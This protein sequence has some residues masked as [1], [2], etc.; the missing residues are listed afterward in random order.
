MGENGLSAGMLPETHLAARVAKLEAERDHWKGVAQRLGACMTC[1]GPAGAPEPYGCTDC[2]NTGFSGEYHTAIAD[3][4]DENSALAAA[5]CVLPPGEGLVGGEGG[6]PFCKVNVEVDKMREEIKRLAKILRENIIANDAGENRLFLGGSIYTGAPVDWARNVLVLI[7]DILTDTA[8]GTMTGE[9][10]AS[11]VR[12]L[13]E[14]ALF[15]ISRERGFVAGWK[16]AKAE[17]IA[18]CEALGFI[19]TSAKDPARILFEE[20]PMPAAAA[21]ALNRETEKA[22]AGGLREAAMILRERGFLNYDEI[23]DRAE[24]IEKEAK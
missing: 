17:M 16:A 19:G 5:A 13:T 22:R 3:L 1:S 4:K 18:L 23:L 24:E 2:L 12:G 15:E 11:D 10:S 21:S 14:D 20:A 8:G 9:P 6:T 7:R